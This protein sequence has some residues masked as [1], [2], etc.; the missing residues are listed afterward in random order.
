MLKRLGLRGP[1]LS[2]EGWGLYN[3]LRD[4]YNMCRHNRD[5]RQ[6]INVTIIVVS[7]QFGAIRCLSCMCRLRLSPTSLLQ[8][9][10]LIY[11]L[12]SLVQWLQKSQTHLL[13]LSLKRST[14]LSRQSSLA[15]ACRS[16]MWSDVA[17]RPRSSNLDSRITEKCFR[18][19]H[20]H[21][22]MH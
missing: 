1:G 19:I 21:A 17:W 20:V 6:S 11:Q 10:V 4:I 9:F 16:L 18:S 3:Y 12:R 7:W 8:V 5:H 14:C 13:Q 22:A 15:D 2:L